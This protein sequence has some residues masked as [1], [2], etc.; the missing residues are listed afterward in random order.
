MQIDL[1]TCIQHIY[2][3]LVNVYVPFE[4]LASL[5]RVYLEQNQVANADIRCGI[6]AVRKRLKPYPRLPTLDG[7]EWYRETLR[8]F[9]AVQSQNG[10]LLTLN[11]AGYPATLA[12]IPDPPLMI[13]AKGS[14]EVLQ[15]EMLAV[16][17]SRKASPFALTE[18]YRLGWH[19]AQGGKAVVS[20]G[21]VGCDAAAHK[22]V[23]DSGCEPCPA[24]MVFAGGLNS[25]Y[26]KMNQWLFD[27]VLSS[28]GLLLSEKLWFQPAMKHSFPVRNR[29]VAGLSDEVIVMQAAKRSGAMI[30]ARQALDQGRDVRVLVHPE[31]GAP[32]QGGHELFLQGAQGFE[33]AESYVKSHFIA[34]QSLLPPEE[35]EFV[36]LTERSD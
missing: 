7:E 1:L 35:N 5:P 6:N 31:A 14:L 22:G 25:L 8:H 34:C 10:Y 9:A 17:G 29:I 26:P 15:L 12:Q 4:G 11:T 13:T 16:V 27:R 21:A 20:G 3:Q 2:S 33:G 18:S 23:A 24:I 32:A 30:T 19:L 28:G 36:S